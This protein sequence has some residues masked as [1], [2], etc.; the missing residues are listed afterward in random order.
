MSRFHLDPLE[1]RRLF[2]AAAFSDGVLTLTG[3]PAADTIRL[4]REPSGNLRASL[5]GGDLGSFA[6]VASVV[7]HAGSGDDTLIV[8]PGVTAPVAYFGDDGTDAAW[9][10]RRVSLSRPDASSVELSRGVN[11]LPDTFSSVGVAPPIASSRAVGN[12]WDEIKNTAD[13]LL[14]SGK[15]TAKNLLRPD[16][17]EPTL[18]PAARGFGDLTGLPLFSDAGPAPTDVAQGA[19]NNCFLLAS[20]ASVAAADPSL[21]RSVITDLGD[22][23]FAVRVMRGTTP[24]FY[25]V[26]A[27]LPLRA[28]SAARLAYAQPGAD[29]SLWVPLIEKAF[30]LDRGGSYRSLDRGGWMDTVYRA[31]GLTARTLAFVNPVGSLTFAGAQLAFGSAV[32]LA[33]KR[34]LRPDVPLTPNHAYSL[35]SVNLSASGT[36]ESVTLLN[37]HA[38]DGY[39]TLPL[40]A[41]RGSV[42]G[43]V[44]G[45]AR[46]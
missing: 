26:D 32:T 39:V 22:G 18:T 43:L 25:R 1:P 19:L 42:A 44:T 45:T 2:S 13:D 31:L 14:S 12:L 28:G 24:K 35:V 41:L 23:T 40:T 15:N 3:T 46:T 11:R 38:L 17:R 16:L 7:V 10:G 9:V 5:N 27:D 36:I 21:V 8:S 4:A 6:S 34:S 33:T 29:N 30:A 37:P 20:L